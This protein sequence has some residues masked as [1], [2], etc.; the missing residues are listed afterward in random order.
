M[1]WEESRRHTPII[2]FAGLPA[3]LLADD[4]RGIGESRGICS[5]AHV[6]YWRGGPSY[7]FM[8]EGMVGDEGFEPPTNS[9]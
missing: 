4:G 3:G 7:G 8:G 2:L 6:P 5:L 1:P 9:V